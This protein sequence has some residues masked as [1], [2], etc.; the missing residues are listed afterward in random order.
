[1]NTMSNNVNELP[2]E[3]KSITNFGVFYEMIC[4]NFGLY[5]KENDDTF[6]NFDKNQIQIIYNAWIE[7]GL[8][9][10]PEIGYNIAFQALKEYIQD[11]TSQKES[12]SIIK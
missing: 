3:F 11:L 8:I 4:I 2:E 10:R 6:I 12:E 1:M 5:C 9:N 7:Y